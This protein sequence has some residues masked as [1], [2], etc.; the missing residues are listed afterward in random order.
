MNSRA[1][2]ALGAPLRIYVPVATLAVILALAGFWPTYFGQLLA[3]T[4]KTVPLIHIHAAVYM[5]WLMLV[6]ALHVATTLLIIAA[7]GRMP[8]W[9]GT[10]AALIHRDAWLSFSGWLAK[11]FLSVS[12]IAVL[13]SG[14]VT[15]ATEPNLLPGK[16]N[17]WG[18]WVGTGGYPD[19][20][21][22]YRSQPWPQVEFTPWGAAESKRLAT[23][24]TSRDA[25]APRGPA[26][27]LTAGGNFPLEIARATKGVVMMFEAAALPR[28]IY[29]DGRE[30]PQ[31]MS[32]TWL[33]HSVGHWEGD[34]LV[35]DTIGVNGR[36]APINGYVANAVHSKTD[37]AARLPVSDRLHM[38][39]RIRVAGGGEYLEDEITIDDPKTYKRPFTVKRYWQRRPDLEVFEY[40]C[41]DDRGIDSGTPAGSQP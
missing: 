28:R 24:P 13:A 26:G 14:S 32:P 1:S 39:E 2:L 33:G 4:L 40:F 20:D 9:H 3:G 19:I 5:G 23:P 17:I 8:V 21:P 35:V 41:E 10:R 30:H 29:T 12:V 27:Y 18:V 38:T 31:D 16:P 22:R 34:T 7:V 15:L 11:F 37:T 6:V 36:T 25:C